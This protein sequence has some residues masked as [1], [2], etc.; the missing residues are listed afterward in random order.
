MDLTGCS[1]EGLTFSAQSLEKLSVLHEDTRS[2]DSSA[3]NTAS[4][5]KEGKG[6]QMLKSLERVLEEDFDQMLDYEDFVDFLDE[7]EVVSLVRPQRIK[8]YFNCLSNGKT[9]LDTERLLRHLKEAYE[10]FVKQSK[11]KEEEEEEE[12]DDNDD[13][14][15]DDDN[16]D[17]DDDDEESVSDIAKLVQYAIEHIKVP[18][19]NGKEVSSIE[20]DNGQR[21]KKPIINDAMFNRKTN[22]KALQ[23]SIL[24]EIE[25]EFME[26]DESNSGRLDFPEFLE[27]IKTFDENCN[28]Q[29]CKYV[30]DMFVQ[31]Q[32]QMDNSIPSTSTIPLSNNSCLNKS[33]SN[34]TELQLKPFFERIRNYAIDLDSPKAV[35]HYIFEKMV[36]VARR[37]RDSIM[38][39]RVRSHLEFNDTDDDGTVS[40]D[41]FFN[42]LSSFSAI[43]KKDALQIFNLNTANG[44]SIRI[45]VFMERL[46]SNKDDHDHSKSID[47]LSKNPLP[48]PHPHSYSRS[49]PHF[50]PPPPSSSSSSSSLSNRNSD[51]DLFIKDAFSAVMSDTQSR[52]NNNGNSEDEQDD[53]KKKMKIMVMVIQMIMV[54]I[55][56]I[57]MV[58]VM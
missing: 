46:D 50:Y 19:N 42:A 13:D 43:A 52:T 34:I 47:A 53:I 8:E 3:A 22:E 57:V 33:L 55:M 48:L 36:P 21:G 23:T 45:D 35:L 58:M 20:H 12:D 14:D 26:L 41:E 27:G 25:S 29:E 37:N 44:K 9:E 56:V 16:D 6:R 54:I 30:F 51:F 39:S 5:E 28:E 15:D 4:G 24:N 49:Y 7:L 18:D 32:Q 38:L 31:M 40:F 11:D 10:S 2:D 17:D 1:L